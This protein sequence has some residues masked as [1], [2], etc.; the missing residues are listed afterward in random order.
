MATGREYQIY[1]DI[2]LYL[3]LQYPNI[4]YH[5]DPTGLN[6]S[7][8]QSGMLKAI[9]GGRGWPDLFIAEPKM[10]GGVVIHS[11]LFIEVKAE[12]IKLFKKDGEP[13]DTH[14]AEQLECGKQLRAQGYQSAIC[15]GWDECQ[16]VIDQY[17]KP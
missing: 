12:G 5:F 2:A 13:V 4:L 3:K 16:R 6:L 1:K 14:V 10:L 9:Q 7:K 8:T 11:G 17:L 15:V